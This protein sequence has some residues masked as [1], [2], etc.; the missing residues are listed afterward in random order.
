MTVRDAL[1]LAMEE[2]MTRDPEVLL[3]G[4]EVGAYHGAYKVKLIRI[5][6]VEFLFIFLG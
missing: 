3:L 2:E 6:F 1:N 4:E 5:F